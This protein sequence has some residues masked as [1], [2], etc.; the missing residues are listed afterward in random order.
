MKYEAVVNIINPYIQMILKNRLTFR[1][2][3]TSDIVVSENVYKVVLDSSI[4]PRGVIDASL[5][6]ILLP[7]YSQL[8][9]GVD[10]EVIFKKKI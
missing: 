9:E 8:T 3:L 5:N 7:K 4:L 1:G 10:Y 2:T 6:N